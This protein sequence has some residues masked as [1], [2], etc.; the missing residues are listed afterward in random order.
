MSR[1]IKFKGLLQ[2][3]G[4]LIPAVVKVDTSGKIIAIHDNDDGLDIDE[5]IDALTL[6]N[7]ALGEP[8]QVN[9]NI[10]DRRIDK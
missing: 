3:E 10:T 4:W 8:S 1:L 6:E 7:Q 5:F 2:K 9:D